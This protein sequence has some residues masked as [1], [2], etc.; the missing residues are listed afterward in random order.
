MFRIYKRILSARVRRMKDMTHLDNVI[1]EVGG[2][3]VLL[4]LLLVVSSLLLHDASL[5]L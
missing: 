5:V 1:D 3:F 4:D 2:D